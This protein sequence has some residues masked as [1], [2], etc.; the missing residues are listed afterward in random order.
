MLSDCWLVERATHHQNSD[1]EAEQADGAAKDLYDEDAH[2]ERGVCRVGQ[3]RARA[4]L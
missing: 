2:E 1:D 3:G 4:N